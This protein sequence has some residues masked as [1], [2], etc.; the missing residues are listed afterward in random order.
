MPL[1]L[2]FIAARLSPWLIAGRNRVFN[3]YDSPYEKVKLKK[4]DVSIGREN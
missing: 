4:D 2:Y 1:W 3:L